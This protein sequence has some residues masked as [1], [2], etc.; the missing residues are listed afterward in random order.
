MRT[1]VLLGNAALAS[2]QVLAHERQAAR[3][4]AAVGD[5]G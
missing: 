3:T 5:A 1:I 4:V 2:A